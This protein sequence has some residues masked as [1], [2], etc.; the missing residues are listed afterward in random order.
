MYLCP[1]HTH[2]NI[3]IEI[4]M[5]M[6]IYMCVCAKNNIGITN[7]FTIV[8]K[9]FGGFGEDAQLQNKLN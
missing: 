9:V 1:T 8:L 6:Y 7:V 2:I 3:Y 5:Y 4:F